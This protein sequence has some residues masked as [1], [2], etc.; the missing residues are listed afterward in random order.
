M[1]YRDLKGEENKQ[2]KR[3]TGVKREVFGQRV[4]AVRKKRQAKRKH[5]KRGVGAKLREEDQ[6]LMLLM[7][8]WD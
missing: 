1:F 4:E 7:Y 5:P 3:H 2:F 8:Y 6:V